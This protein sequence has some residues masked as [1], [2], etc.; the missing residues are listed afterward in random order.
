MA[1]A[2]IDLVP[3]QVLFRTGDPVKSLYVVLQGSVRLV[4]HQVNGATVVLQRAHAQQLLAEASLFASRYHCDAMSEHGARL[5]RVSKS[6]IL[7]AQRE[8]AG[9]LTDLAAHLAGEVQQARA[10]AEL[11]S[12]RSVADRL[13][14]WLALHGELPPRGRWIDVAQEIGV[15]PEALYRELAR[16][17]GFEKKN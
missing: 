15:S 2:E 1:E 11:L 10:R 4:R 7:Q 8:N 17:P 16:R 5:A 9:W 13:S 12:L 6:K 14:G 3:G